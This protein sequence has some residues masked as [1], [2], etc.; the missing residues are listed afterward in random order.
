MC[1]THSY[2]RL[3]RVRKYIHNEMPREKRR[4]AAPFSSPEKTKHTVRVEG[5]RSR[6]GPGLAPK[7]ITKFFLS[8][9]SSS[10]MRGGETKTF[11]ALFSQA[12]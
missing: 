9:N 3:G 12:D 1:H 5:L 6:G 10:Q 4:D 11:Q 8:F 2:L 7:I